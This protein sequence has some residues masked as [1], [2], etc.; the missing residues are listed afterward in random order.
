MGHASITEISSDDEL[1]KPDN[2]VEVPEIDVPEVAGAPSGPEEVVIAILCKTKAHVLPEYLQCLE[3]Q[4]Y[5]KALCHLYV[6][7]NNNSDATLEILQRWLGRVGDQYASV[8]LE[9]EDV[10]ERVQDMGQ[11]EWN[12]VRFKVLGKIRQGSID[13]A[14]AKDAHYFVVDWSVISS[15]LLAFG[16]LK[17]FR[18]SM[19]QR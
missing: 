2:E 6:R 15:S 16:H 12:A 3:Q 14:I 5:P 8:K 9:A 7:T 1:L 19:M 10:P 18:S 4:T 13:H 11:H 17:F